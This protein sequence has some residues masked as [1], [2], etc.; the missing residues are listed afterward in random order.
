MRTLRSL[1]MLSAVILLASCIIVPPPKGPKNEA[2]AEDPDNPEANPNA[3]LAETPP[4]RDPAPAD[5]QEPPPPPPAPPKS[6]NDLVAGLGE[7]PWV[8]LGIKEPG[9]ETEKGAV[10][11]TKKKGGFSELVFIVGE[12]D[13]EISKVVVV[14]GNGDRWDPK[15]KQTF[16][17]G[18]RTRKVDLPGNARWIRKINF[19][20][21]SM[22]KEAKAQLHVFGKQM[23]KKEKPAPAAAA[24]TNNTATAAVTAGTATTTAPAT[25]ITMP[26]AKAMAPAEMMAE[27]GKDDPWFVLGSREVA[28]GETTIT[29]NVGKDKGKFLFIAM[30]GTGGTFKLHD[31]VVNF[32]DGTKHTAKVKHTFKPNNLTR[33]ISFEGG[34]RKEI[35]SVDFVITNEADAADGHIHLFG[36]HQIVKK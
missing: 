25:A 8:H 4:P 22:N 1:F 2:A 12:A 6:V 5:E 31:W 16:K 30:G 21:A 32:E 34:A 35:K 27:L 15:I 7:G 3:A 14:F 11:V 28:A 33:R 19:E 10:R 29:I 20:Y 13:L 24:A 18:S 26:P 9:F 17:A 23:E 36:L